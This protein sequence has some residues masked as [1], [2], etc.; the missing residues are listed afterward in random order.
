MNTAS[1]IPLSKTEQY[2]LITLLTLTALPHALNIDS[3]ISALFVILVAYRLLAIEKP[4]LRPGKLLLFLFTLVALGNVL[5]LYPILFGREAGVA[6][7]TSM[8]ALKLMEMRV[9]RDVYILIFIGYFTLITQFLYRDMFWLV[10]YA[11]LLVLALT[12]TLVESSRYK[13]STRFLQPF[14]IALSLV[15]QALPVM[16]LLFV[17]F[18][19]INTPLW[20]LGTETE[21]AVSG[22][23]GTISPGNF[24]QLG[25]SSAVAF[26]VDFKSEMPEP[27]QR[28]WRGPV[29]WLTDG[30]SWRADQQSGEKAGKFKRLGEPIAYSV[31][32]EP[33]PGSWLYTLELPSAYPLSARL[34]ADYQLI[35]KTPIKRRLRYDAASVLEY[36]TGELSEDERAKGVQLPAS[37]TPRMR[38]LVRNWQQQSSSNEELVLQT[39][40]FF[41]TEE[42][43]YT[44]NPPLLERNPADQFL[45][46]TR[47]GF[48][49]H[50]ATSFTLLMRIAGI[51]ARVIGGYQG[52]EV[53]PLGDYLIVRQS[54][55]HAWSE[56][57]LQGR[58]WQRIDP[59][60]A[61]APERIQ[62]SLDPGLISDVIGA[63]ILFGSVESGLLSAA[64]RQM[65]WGVDALNAGWH[66]WVL[67][68][69]RES[70]HYLMQLMGIGFLR[71]HKLAY[72]MVAITGLFLLLLTVVLLYRVRQK[73]DPVQSIYQNFCRRLQ[74]KGIVRLLHEGPRDFAKRVT[75]SRPDLR[76]S[77][78]V[79]TGLYI[80]IRYG[81][82]DSPSNRRRFRQ[83]VRRFHP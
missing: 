58:G 69:T 77:V 37:I 75:D 63:P 34:Q 80:G 73:L 24:S 40:D 7:L 54:D 39:L 20:N 38:E 29:F 42:F 57:W 1:S 23:S 81:R 49:E 10:I 30:K 16:V 43:Y 11:L 9:R 71:G 60:V 5:V 70:Q 46:E 67:G 48:C 22:V 78:S 2:W 3:R 64:L 76:N 66:R 83:L 28:Y 44:L 41:R 18:P 65:R 50:F 68:Y 53:N 59:T 52:G 55:A 51:P 62:Q 19:R 74:R 79:I 35:S 6:L 33:T 14:G 12:A 36:Q 45:F 27:A 25:R 31:T 17:F 4:R 56:V 21:Q 61:V 15:A 13:P 82:L 72:G 26:R 47:R 8:L 32:L